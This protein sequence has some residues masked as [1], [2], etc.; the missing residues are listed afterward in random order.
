MPG[1]M[2]CTHR[3]DFCH[4]GCKDVGLKVLEGKVALPSTLRSGGGMS[5]QNYRNNSE[6][7][8]NLNNFTTSE[9]SSIQIRR[10]SLSIWHS[11]HPL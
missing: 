1:N 6:W 4:D 2:Q 10:V 9:S 7:E 5:V 11:Q 3:A 8:S